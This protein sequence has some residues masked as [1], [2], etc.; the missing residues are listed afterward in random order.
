MIE[1]TVKVVSRRACYAGDCRFVVD[2]ARQ[3][4]A[5]LLRLIAHNTNNITTTEVV[6]AL[7][8]CWRQR[9]STTGASTDP[10]ID[11]DPATVAVKQHD[12]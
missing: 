1:V 10:L 3:D 6:C 4:G 12:K 11:A 7:W 2:Y 9:P 5:F 8:D